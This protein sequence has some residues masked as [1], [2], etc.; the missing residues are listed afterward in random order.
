MGR[1]P[2]WV[3]AKTGRAPMRSPGRPPEATREQRRRFWVL[4]AEGKSS[5]EAAAEV[6]VSAPVGSRWFRQ[7]GGM[8]PL[9]LT[10]ISARYLSFPDREDIAMLRAKGHG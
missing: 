3:T 7:S 10:P 1:P 6:G 5:E 9:P 4:I 2:G 8:S